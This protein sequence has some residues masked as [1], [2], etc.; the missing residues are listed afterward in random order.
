MRR[1]AQVIASKS[2]SMPRVLPPVGG[3]VDHLH[4]SGRAA[5][6]SDA[7]SP[8]VRRESAPG[9]D[10]SWTGVRRDFDRGPAGER[11]RERSGSRW[12]ASKTGGV[13]FWKDQLSMTSLRGAR[14]RERAPRD[15]ARPAL[16]RWSLR[17]QKAGP[18]SCAT[19]QPDARA[20]TDAQP[21]I[22][23][24]PRASVPLSL[25]EEGDRA[26]ARRA[27][28]LAQ[29]SPLLLGPWLSS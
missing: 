17:R 26:L 16:E 1:I 5:G 13:S 24:L 25:P 22:V 27:S 3:G 12:V 7:G 18:V 6:S 10:G 2:A 11:L 15:H 29:S 4:R 23:L 9:L 8:G 14:S 19:R 28:S 21:R 20:A